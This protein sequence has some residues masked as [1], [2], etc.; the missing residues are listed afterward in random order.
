ML[1]SSKPAPQ[2]PLRGAQSEIPQGELRE[3]YRIRANTLKPLQIL[4]FRFA[5]RFWAKLP[6]G[7]TMGF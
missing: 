6:K 4:T 1:I 5:K 3:I 7:F 2:N